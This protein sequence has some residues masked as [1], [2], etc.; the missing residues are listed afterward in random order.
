[1]KENVIQHHNQLLSIVI[2]KYDTLRKGRTG[3]TK[4]ATKKWVKEHGK[5]P[6]I[7]D[8]LIEETADVQDW[9][10][11]EKIR[12]SMEILSGA[13]EELVFP[14]IVMSK[15]SRSN[16]PSA[17]ELKPGQKGVVWFCAQEI[18]KKQTKNG[19]T[20]YTF[21]A[22]D[23]NNDIARIRVWGTFK[24][25][26]EPYTIWLAEVEYDSNWGMSSSAMKMRKIEV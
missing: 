8:Q 17:M 21:T 7:I 14:P 19:K 5:E 23:N 10:R 2:G 4:T 22:L 18:V 3:M 13:N 9:S 25:E 1:M 20:F 6:R 24:E 26:P 15:I 12:H 11:Y 16:V